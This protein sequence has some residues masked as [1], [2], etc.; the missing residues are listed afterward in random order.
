MLIGDG[1]LF[2]SLLMDLDEEEIEGGKNEEN[3]TKCSPEKRREWLE[4]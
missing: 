1:F 2:E 4:N 3:S